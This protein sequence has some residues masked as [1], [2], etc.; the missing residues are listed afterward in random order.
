[1]SSIINLLNCINKLKTIKSIN[2]KTNKKNEMKKVISC[3]TKQYGI[4]NL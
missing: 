4:L 3:Y 1:M 2:L